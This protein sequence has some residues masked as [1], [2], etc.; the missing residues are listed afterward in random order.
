MFYTYETPKPKKQPTHNTDMNAMKNIIMRINY[1]RMSSVIYLIQCLEV[2]NSILFLLW[3]GKSCFQICL[4]SVR[5]VRF[6]CHVYEIAREIK[7]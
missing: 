5:F 1:F 6:D 2:E 7:V 3:L 4:P